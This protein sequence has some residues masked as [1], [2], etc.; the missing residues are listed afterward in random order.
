M[1]RRL[2]NWLSSPGRAVNVSPVL[3]EFV[4]SL[5]D[6]ERILDLGSGQRRLHETAINF[7]I[8][9]SEHVSVVGDAH[10]LPFKDE[11]MDKVIVTALLEHVKDPGLVVSEIHRVLK[12]G[13]EI[14]AEVPFIQGF[15][16]DPGDFNRWT[17]EGT[18][19]LFDG[20]VHLSSGVCVGP[21]SGI[22]W[23]CREFLEGVVPVPQLRPAARFIVGWL[24]VPLLYLDR[25]AARR[26]WANKIAG[27]FYFWGSRVANPVPG[28]DLI[29]GP[30]STVRGRGVTDSGG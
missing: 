16:N 24:L 1:M 18:K 22:V 9:P 5:R 29:D 12:P 23:I 28:G 30:Y 3:P 20:F 7:D 13:G 2:R 8:K 10:F 21:A 11:V 19:Q 27:G 6:S 25:F 14:Y 17:L 15:H 26:H 4:A